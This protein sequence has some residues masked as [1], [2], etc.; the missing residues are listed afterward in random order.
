M[1]G[2]FITAYGAYGFGSFSASRYEVSD[3]Q[4]NKICVERSSMLAN[5]YDEAK[6]VLRKNWAFVERLAAALVEKDTVLYD[7]LVA[8]REQSLAA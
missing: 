8:L 2:R 4:M 5:F 7:E 1:V 3:A 6:E